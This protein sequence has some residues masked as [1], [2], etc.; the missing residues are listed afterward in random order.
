VDPVDVLI[1]AQGALMGL[2]LTLFAF[3]AVATTILG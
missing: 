2:V 3:T 1:D